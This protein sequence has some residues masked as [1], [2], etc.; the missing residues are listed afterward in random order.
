VVADVVATLRVKGELLSGD[1]HNVYLSDDRGQLVDSVNRAGEVTVALCG[2]DQQD[3]PATPQGKARTECAAFLVPV[4]TTVRGVVYDDLG[5]D[6][7]RTHALLF[8]VD[9]PA[10]GSVTLP[11]GDGRVGE[12]PVEVTADGGEHAQVVLADIIDTPSAYFADAKA[13]PGTSLHVLRYA[14]RASGIS[15]VRPVG[16][17]ISLAVLDDHGLPIPAEDHI[18]FELRDCPEPPV[19]IPSGGTAQ[20]CLVF[21]VSGQGKISR[22]VYRTDA[23]DADPA[24]WQSWELAG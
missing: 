6:P 16:V 18:H 10:T 7:L 8:P 5:D 3:L 12:T 24:N 9:L 17:A 19:E 21:V 13:P 14:V 2:S 1:G 20:G 15:S 23:H 22:I 11:V 4:A